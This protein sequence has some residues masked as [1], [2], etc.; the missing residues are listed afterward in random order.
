MSRNSPAA[1][2]VSRPPEK[3]VAWRGSSRKDVRDFPDDA[4]TEAGYQLHLL[5]QGKQPAD[6]KPMATVGPGVYEIRIHTA[7]E[8]RVLVVA[9]F[10]EAVYVLHAFEKKSQKTAKYDIELARR[11]YRDLIAGRKE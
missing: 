8:Y 1:A 7:T 11:R 2:T 9:K 6:W 3:P 4:R 5:Q 10:A